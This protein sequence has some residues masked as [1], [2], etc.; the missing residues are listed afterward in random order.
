MLSGRWDEDAVPTQNDLIE[1]ILD[2]IK[3]DVRMK[4]VADDMYHVTPIHGSDSTISST[5]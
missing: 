3:P 1:S 5:E 2:D 4:T